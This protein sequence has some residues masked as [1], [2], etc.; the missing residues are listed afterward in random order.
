MLRS[1]GRISRLCFG[2]ESQC[3]HAMRSGAARRGAAQGPMGFAKGISKQFVP[4]EKEEM[5]KLV[6]VQVAADALAL[7]W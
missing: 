2:C 3:L 7:A 1:V 5:K 6:V 4:I